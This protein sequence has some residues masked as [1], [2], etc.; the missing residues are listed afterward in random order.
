MPQH[1]AAIIGMVRPDVGPH[2]ETFM[3]CSPA[4]C[5]FSARC[6]CVSC[7]KRG[8]LLVGGRANIR[9]SPFPSSSPPKAANQRRPRLRISADI[10]IARFNDV[11]RVL[12][13]VKG[14]KPAQREQR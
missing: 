14:T 13:F 12:F 2:V 5:C 6:P 4:A 8:S 10:Q 11:L 9:P 3:I 1:R 7:A